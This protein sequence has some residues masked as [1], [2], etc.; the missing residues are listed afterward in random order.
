MAQWLEREFTDRKVRG[1]IP[2]SASRLLLS[3]LEQIGSIPALVLQTGGMGVRHRK[4]ARAE[5]MFLRIFISGNMHTVLGSQSKDPTRSP[6]RTLQSE[7]VCLSAW[8]SAFYLPY[9]SSCLLYT[10]LLVLIDGYHLVFAQ[11][12]TRKKKAE[13]DKYAISDRSEWFKA[14]M[15]QG[16]PSTLYSPNWDLLDRAKYHAVPQSYGFKSVG[17]NQ[18]RRFMGPHGFWL[19]PGAYNLQEVDLST[20]VEIRREFNER[21]IFSTNTL[22]LKIN[23]V[24]T[25]DSSESLVYDVFQ[26]NVLHT[27]LL[28]FQLVRYSRYRK[29]TRNALLIMLL[30]ILRQSTTGFALP[31]RAH[32]VGA[33]PEVPSTW[34]P[35]ESPNFLK[36]HCLDLSDSV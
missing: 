31:V 27:G 23:L 35:A 29:Y 2:T 6:L 4:G 15:P 34:N 5:R 8:G 13:W 28:M 3:R 22:I 12:L 17:R 1:S 21:G 30:K 14:L 20:C 33:V 25:G 36:Y 26:L 11:S 32:Q 7:L 9:K 16:P 24:F 18:D 10:H 19:L